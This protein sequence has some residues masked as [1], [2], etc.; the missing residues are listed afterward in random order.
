METIK[1]NI[2]GLIEF[3]PRIYKDER[4]EFIETYKESLFK[5]NGITETFVQDNQSI[6]ALGVFR[7]IHL[8]TGS[9]AQ[10]KL[11]RVAKGGVLDFAVDL[12]PD[13]PTFG[14][15]QSV[16][17]TAEMGNQFWV[18]AGFGHAFLSLEDDTIFCYKCTK[19][20]D[21]SAEECILWSD[22]DLNLTIAKEI[23]GL[24]ISEVKVSEKDSQGITVKQFIE[25][26]YSHLLV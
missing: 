14:Q 21:K 4:G 2:D 1:F 5:E 6:S 16:L 18:P 8:Q 15:W 19:E 24:G 7:G 13:S 20:Y 12:R 9:S 3:R 10:G 11:V 26:H 17:L 23:L 22:K 25:K